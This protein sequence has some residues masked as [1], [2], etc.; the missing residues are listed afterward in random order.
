MHFTT[1]KYSENVTY[2]CVFCP[3]VFPELIEPRLKNTIKTLYKFLKIICSEYVVVYF[4]N[5]NIYVQYTLFQ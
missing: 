3:C 4:K 5:E 2:C 1:E